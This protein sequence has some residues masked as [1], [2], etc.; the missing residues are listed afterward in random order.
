MIDARHPKSRN[1]L[2][3]AVALC[4]ATATLAASAAQHGIVEAVMLARKRAAEMRCRV[5]DRVETQIRAPDRQRR[6]LQELGGARVEC[7]HRE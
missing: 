2:V 6:G 1:A 3:R 5:V 7:R 4:F